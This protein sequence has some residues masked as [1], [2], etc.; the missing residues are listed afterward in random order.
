MHNNSACSAY[1]CA[2]RLQGGI[3][4]QLFEL[5]LGEHLGR[6][7]QC[8]I[9]YLNDA[10]EN[11]PYHRSN[12][13]KVLFPNHSFVTMSSI[14]KV[15]CRILNERI[16]VEPLQP[17][18]LKSLMAS[19]QIDTCI[20]DGYWQDARYVSS[21][22]KLQVHKA[23]NSIIKTSQAHGISDAGRRL[24]HS[25]CPVAVHLRRH[26]YKH[27]GI[28]DEA[29]YIDALR[30]I[31]VHE[32]DAEFF[33]FSDEPNY[34]GHFLL[35]SGI[36]HSMVQSGDDLLDLALMTRCRMHIIANSTFSWWG[37][38]LA[39]TRL[40]IYPLPWSFVHSPAKTLFPEN[41]R[42]IA[43]AVKGF[44]ADSSFTE[45]FKI[46]DLAVEPKLVR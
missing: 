2:I 25:Q 27:H 5:A 42:P 38:A 20:L 43:Q 41:W 35:Q 6:D 46:I 19:N 8:D 17:T 18:Y 44:V 13:A 22:F 16:L 37:A 36:P 15:H 39:D 30:W 40:T 10:F 45:Q 34:T 21:A 32:P 28:C 12:I 23:L 31:R 4:N 1:Q 29:Y 11:D 26:D 3:G 14:L 24:I 9:C 33:I 7:N